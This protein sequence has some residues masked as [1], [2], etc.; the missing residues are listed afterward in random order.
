M[1]FK[2]RG[3]GSHLQQNSPDISRDLLDSYLV[4]H[5]HVLQDTE[6]GEGRDEPAVLFPAQVG[7]VGVTIL[8]PCRLLYSVL[9]CPININTKCLEFQIN[10]FSQAIVLENVEWGRD[11]GTEGG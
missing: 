8:S 1:S 9:T 5:S 7:R 11:L 10:S 4:F 2:D 3:K 6:Q